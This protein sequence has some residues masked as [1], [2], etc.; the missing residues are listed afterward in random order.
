[1]QAIQ[2]GRLL[3]A[4]EPERWYIGPRGGAAGVPESINMSGMWSVLFV[5]V[6]TV[7]GGPKT[8]FWPRVQK[9]SIFLKKQSFFNCI[10][11]SFVT[12]LAKTPVRV[13]LQ[14]LVLL[15]VICDS[16]GNV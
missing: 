7:I 8:V 12:G 5:L 3:V 2:G 11:T 1:M 13:A 15:R 4:R 6:Y 16:F 14:D 9:M 10:P